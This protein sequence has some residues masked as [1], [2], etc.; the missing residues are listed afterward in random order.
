MPAVWLAHYGTPFP[1]NGQWLS[2]L[3]CLV[4]LSLYVVVSLATGGG[5]SFNLERMLH[6][7]VYATDP[8]EHEARSAPA[9]GWQAAF[10]MGPEFSAGDKVF[11][12]LYAASTV[13]WCLVFVVVSIMHFGFDA[14]PDRFW[15]GFWRVYLLLLLAQSVPGVIWFAVGGVRDVRALLR[16]LQTATSE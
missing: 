1:V 11:A 15:A 5:R 6:R 16:E 8:H 2:L 3:A 12:V 9:R 4:A 7:G 13:G 10:G 14:I